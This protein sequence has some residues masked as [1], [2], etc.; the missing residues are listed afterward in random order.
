MIT[1]ELYRYFLVQLQ[2]IY[3]LNEATIITDWVFEKI[4]HVSK[5]TLLKN[6]NTLVSVADHGL[7]N[8]KLLQLLNHK[9]VQYVL[10]EAWFYNIKLMVNEQVLI[11]RPETEELVALILSD[12]KKKKTDPT[13]MDIGTGSGCIPIALKKHLPAATVSAIDISNDA[14]EVAKANAH[15][16]QTPVQ[17]KQFNFLDEGNWNRFS[18]YDIIVSNPP[19]IPENEKQK[20]EKNVVD[21]EPH[22][23][24]FVPNNEPL[25]FYKK[26]ATFG[27][28]HLNEGGKIYMETHEDF[29]EEVAEH[30][31]KHYPRVVLKKDIFEKNRIVTAS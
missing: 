25:L 21:N 19:Y 26:I 31:K 16:C 12:L 11:P 18:S 20:L 30:F 24:L 22:T 10:G 13:I 4:L 6:P 28:K 8:H 23:A 17:F 29:A 14:L 5:T 3:S 2:E 7:L 15:Q 1:K 9:P 27:K